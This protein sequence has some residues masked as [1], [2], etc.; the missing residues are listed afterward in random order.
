[1]LDAL[2]PA[3]DAFASAVQAGESPAAAWMAALRAAEAGTA[4]TAAMRPRLGRAAY[5]GERVLGVPDAG[6]SAVLVWMK[7][8]AARLG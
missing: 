6:A 8:V 1:M 4:A 3:A 2:Q 7:A 5:L